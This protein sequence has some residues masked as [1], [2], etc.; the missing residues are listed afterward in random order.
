M[1]EKLILSRTMAFAITLTIRPKYFPLS[2]ERQLDISE[3]DILTF[4]SDMDS[5]GFIIAEITKN[6]NIHYHGIIDMN[7]QNRY[8]QKIDLYIKDYFR[9]SNKIGF[10]CVKPITDEVRWSQYIMKDLNSTNAFLERNPIRFN[11]NGK[12]VFD[13]DGHID[14]MLYYSKEYISK[15]SN[16]LGEYKEFKEY[17]NKIV[18][19]T[20][21]KVL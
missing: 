17:T 14:N 6:A 12:S 16:I 11:S 13:P 15:N 20:R 18:N 2:L 5:R 3:A 8:H 4:L 19:K 9:Y 1:C 21:V 7:L 10:V